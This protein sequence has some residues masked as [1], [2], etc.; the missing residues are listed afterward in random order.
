M[1]VAG[2]GTSLFVPG[3][4]MF[5]SLLKEGFLLVLIIS[6]IPLLISMVVS[7]LFSILQAA[8]QIQEQSI[9]HLVKF[10]TVSLIFVIAGASFINLL[11][12]F[13]EESF[14]AIGFV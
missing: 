12:R 1:D 14:G 11:V 4:M 10:L 5:D 8:T 6:G 3:G 9:G 7:L 13:I 2:E